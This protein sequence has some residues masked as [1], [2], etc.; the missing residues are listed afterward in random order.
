MVKLLGSRATSRLEELNAQ[1]K[2]SLLASTSDS[3]QILPKET[4]DMGSRNSSESFSIR[5]SEENRSNDPTSDITEVSKC[6]RNNNKGN[7][8]DLI[9]LIFRL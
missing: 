2:A 7:T 3:H 9:E 4:S 1:I 5:D 6:L 8:C